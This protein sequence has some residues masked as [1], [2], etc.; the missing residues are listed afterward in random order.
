MQTTTQERSRVPRPG[1]IAKGKP[2]RGAKPAQSIWSQGLALLLLV[3]FAPLYA[4]ISAA[5]FIFHGRPVLYRARRVGYGGRPFDMLKFRTMHVNSKPVVNDDMKVLVTPRD[6]RVTTFGRLLRCGLDEIPQIWN[7][8]RG[9]M[10]WV[11]PRPDEAWIQPY[12]GPALA[13]RLALTPGVTGLA[14]VLDARNLT[15][16]EAYSLDLWYREYRTHT[17]DALVILW[18]VPYVLGWR[19]I[20]ARKLGSIRNTP[21]YKHMLDQCRQELTAHSHGNRRGFQI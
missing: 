17:L 2:H 3:A 7:V 13:G 1:R 4:L 8:L 20:G 10:T 19:S 16:P 15:A 9:D 11:G 6:P 12:Y 14:Q 5:I 21:E 18:T